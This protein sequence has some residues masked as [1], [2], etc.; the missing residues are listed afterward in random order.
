MVAAHCVQYKSMGFAKCAATNA[1]WQKRHEKGNKEV[2][3]GWEKRQPTQIE[4]EASANMIT[5]NDILK[6]GD[7]MIV[8]IAYRKHLLPSSNA[9]AKRE[10]E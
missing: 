2:W 5:S 8:R 1:K 9:R 7:S 6:I 10:H 4:E 3:G